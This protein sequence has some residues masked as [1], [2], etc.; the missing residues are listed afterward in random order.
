MYDTLEVRWILHGPLPRGV[1]EWFGGGAPEERTDRYLALG[2][3]PGL[4][5][6]VRGGSTLEIKAL[7]ADRDSRFNDRATGRVE[8]WSKWSVDVDPRWPETGLD[9]NWVPV[10]KTRRLRRFV[11]ASSAH[12]AATVAEIPPREDARSACDAELT[13]L[14]AFGETSWTLGF[15]AF[16]PA[17]E[18]EA[19]VPAAVERVL[20]GLP[21]DVV[22]ALHRSLSYP[23]WIAVGG[24]PDDAGGG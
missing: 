4:G 19:T 14:S 23:A 17:E 21:G 16:G 24:H 15:E 12:D 8:A 1:V 22:L 11:P 9:A 10:R 6:K 7:A 3:G 20:P 13:E 18:R 2:P 5:V